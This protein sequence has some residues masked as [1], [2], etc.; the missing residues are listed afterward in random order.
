MIGYSSYYG[1]AEDPTEKHVVE[2]GGIREYTKGSVFFSSFQRWTPGRFW[3]FGQNTKVVEYTNRA[4]KGWLT[5]TGLDGPTTKETFYAFQNVDSFEREIQNQ[6]VTK[7]PR[8][9]ESWGT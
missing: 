2:D 5:L 9:P 4:G 1:G 3:K 8:Y 7:E 6:G